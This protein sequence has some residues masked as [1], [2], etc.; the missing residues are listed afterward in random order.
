M[1]TKLDQAQFCTGAFYVPDVPRVPK[2][3]FLNEGANVCSV[4]GADLVG[5]VALLRINAG[6]A[7]YAADHT[8]I[9]F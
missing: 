8:D 1:S 5:S 7:Q 2:A 6:P 4:E 3:M 9:D